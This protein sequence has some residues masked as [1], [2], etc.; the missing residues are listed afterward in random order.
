M[1]RR[2]ALLRMTGLAVGRF[3]RCDRSR[4]GWFGRALQHRV[5]GAEFGA[6]NALPLGYGLGEVLARRG[7]S[8]AR[9]RGWSEIALFLGVEL[10]DEGS[11]QRGKGRRRTLTT[12]AA[13][14]TA[15]PARHTVEL[16]GDCRRLTRYLW[17]RTI[18]RSA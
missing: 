10:T 11:V 5:E 6:G 4:D 7:P 1:T 14:P 8:G 18:R 16:R 2:A 15:L 12:A 13:S 17:R 3:A 9:R